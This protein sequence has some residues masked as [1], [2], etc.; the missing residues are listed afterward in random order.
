MISSLRLSISTSPLKSF[1]PAITIPP[2]KSTTDSEFFKQSEPGELETIGEDPEE[3]EGAV[4]P[5]PECPWQFI[6]S[7]GFICPKPILLWA[8]FAGR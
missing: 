2:E 6:D 3:P 8:A 4:E 5:E 1:A 7:F